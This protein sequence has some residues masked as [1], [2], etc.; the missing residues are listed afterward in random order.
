MITERNM[1]RFCNRAQ[2]L[3]F[4]PMHKV[5]TTTILVDGRDHTLNIVT[6]DVTVKLPWCMRFTALA[7]AIATGGAR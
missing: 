3:N 7:L 6:P 1:L 5:G 2:C 4:A